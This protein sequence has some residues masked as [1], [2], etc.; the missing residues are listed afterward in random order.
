MPD[1]TFNLSFISRNTS[2]A[3]FSS[4]SLFFDKKFCKHASSWGCAKADNGNIWF[5][6]AFV[7]A[8]SFL[9]SPPSEESE[10]ELE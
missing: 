1:F 10:S 7:V 2:A 4:M 9:T 6:E 8:G 5:N 3:K